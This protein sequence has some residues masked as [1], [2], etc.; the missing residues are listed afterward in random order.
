[1]SGR[2]A[3]ATIALD[4]MPG[5][6]ERNFISLANA[7]ARRGHTVSLITFDQ[8]DARSFYSIDNDVR[9]YKVGVSRP[10]GSISFGDRL[11]LMRVIRAALREARVSVVVCFHHG[12]LIRFILA[13]LFTGVRLVVSERNSPTLYNHIRQ[14]KWNVNFLSLF[15]ADRI[16]VQFPRY[17]EEYPSI[18]R[19]RISAIP[20][21]VSVPTSCTSPGVGVPRQGEA[22]QLLAIGRLCAQK[23]YEALIEAFAALAPRHPAWELVIVGNGEAQRCIAADIAQH[24]LKAR[25]RL[26]SPVTADMSHIYKRASLFCMPSQWEGFPNAL[27]EAMAHGLP[28]VG[29]RGCAGVND[30]IVHGENGLLAEG[31]GDVKSL[32][33]TLDRLMADSARRKE[34]GETA[35]KSVQRFRPEL[36]YSHWEDLLNTVEKTR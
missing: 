12:I 19:S 27:A 11:R 17:A 31:N 6:L 7:L 10:H 26:M 15:F 3:L 35:A 30:L 4:D 18:L 36:I 22:L 34:M 33:E 5:G 29:Y 28:V 21:P 32:F 25:V 9:W 2:Y 14:S 13:T 24:G 1:M 8:Q 20:N 16:T 23:N